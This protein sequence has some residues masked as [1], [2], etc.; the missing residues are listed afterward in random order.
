MTEPTLPA[1]IAALLSP[2]A[3]PHPVDRVELVQTHISYVLLA[4]EYVYKIKKPLDLGFLDYSTLEKRRLYCQEEVR[5]NARFCP[6][7][8]LG[9]SVITDDANGARV[10]GAGRVVE[11]AVRMRR[12]PADKMMAHLLERG[13]VTA[14]MVRSLGQRLA[15]FHAGADTNE[16][17]AGFGRVGTVAANWQE[18][19][20]QTA[21]FIGRTVSREQ[22]DAI[23]AYVDRFIAAN[24]DLIERRADEGRARDCHGDLRAD[25]V[26]FED[27][28]ICVFDCIEFNDRIRFSDVASDLAFLAMDLDFRGHPGLADELTGAYIET[29]LDS[30]LSLVFNFYRCYRAYVRGKVDGFQVDEPEVP[31]VQREEARRKAQAYFRL[32]AAYAGQPTPP[33]VIAMSGFTGSGKTYLGDALAGRLGAFVSWSDVVRKRLAGIDPTQP[34]RVPFESGIYSP[35]MTEQTY[36]ALV[37]EARPFVQRRQPVLLD[38][39]FLRARQRALARGLAQAAGA[40]FLLVECRVP[41]AVAQQRLAVRGERRAVSDGRP[42]I[43]RAQQSVYEPPDELPPGERLVLDSSRPLPELIATVMGRLGVPYPPAP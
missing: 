3:Y 43:Y 10:D 39:T 12:L 27:D 25:A 4:G 11:Y 1:L 41:D 36:A 30:T 37:D 26:V 28:G 20:E 13:G 35:E 16:R 42:E 18:N 6:R 19:F 40:Q 38:A 22:F 15:S 29:A 21:P 7:T 33:V 34:A 5:L 2:E 31:E 23:Y 8:Y 24:G 14:P 32:A 9:V 17:I